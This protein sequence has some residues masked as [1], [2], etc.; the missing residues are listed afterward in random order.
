MSYCERDRI[1]CNLKQR[2][3]NNRLSGRNQLSNNKT[4]AWYLTKSS[5]K[6]NVFFYHKDSSDRFQQLFILEFSFPYFKSF[7]DFLIMY[8]FFPFSPLT[9]L[10]FLSSKGGAAPDVERT[11]RVRLFLVL[12]VSVRRE[13]E[14][15]RERERELF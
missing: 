5:F 3:T 4:R 11:E 15:D 9:F 10:L 2:A 1:Y 12:T 8:N 7:L 14:R 13:R 6:G